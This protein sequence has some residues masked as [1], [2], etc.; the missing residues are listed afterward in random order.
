MS[1]TIFT[2]GICTLPVI[3]MPGHR[4][5]IQVM[6]SPSTDTPMQNMGTGRI[7]TNIRKIENLSHPVLASPSL[8]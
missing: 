6:R 7:T 1:R 8:S 2:G 4:V 3:S 5:P